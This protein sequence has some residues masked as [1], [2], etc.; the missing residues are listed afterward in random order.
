MIHLTLLR[1]LRVG[2]ICLYQDED[3]LEVFFHLNQ[4]LLFHHRLLSKKYR[5]LLEVG[6]V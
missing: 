4:R 2:P 6:L 5:S 3:L 1:H